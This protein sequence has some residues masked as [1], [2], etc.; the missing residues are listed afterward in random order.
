MNQIV[1]LIV[2]YN[3]DI[4]DC[5]AY[6]GLKDCE[7]IDIMIMDNSDTKNTNKE[8]AIKHNLNY[9]NNKGNIGLT[10]SFNKA[11][12][13]LK[14][15]YSYKYIL[16][17]DDDTQ[18][19]NDY[20]NEINELTKTSVN[21]IIPRLKDTNLGELV[22]PK[23]YNYTSLLTKVYNGQKYKHIKAVNSGLC[24]NL[25]VFDHFSYNENNFLYFAD[26]DFFQNFVNKTNTSHVITKTILEH[27]FSQF[28]KPQLDESSY[29]QIKIR[30]KDSRAYNNFFIHLL[31]KFGFLTNLYLHYKD[32]NLIKLLKE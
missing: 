31:Y 9:I 22:S 26:V 8:Y 3:K 2:I 19:T 11:I 12:E 16:L 29:K 21:V 30:L 13:I 15:Q 5:A 20:I 7:N 23:V 32:I 1:A 28:E 17:C 10:K 4:V 18:F 24:I 14:N 6:N 25:D 27:S